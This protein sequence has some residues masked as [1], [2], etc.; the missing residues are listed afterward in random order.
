MLAKE[1]CLCK[2]NLFLFTRIFIIS[3]VSLVFLI[4]WFSQGLPGSMR[5]AGLLT[6][7]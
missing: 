4:C 1:P 7:P 3:F 2:I 6:E 5:Y